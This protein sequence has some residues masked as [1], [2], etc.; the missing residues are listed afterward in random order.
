ML[1]VEFRFFFV[2]FSEFFMVGIWIF[3][4]IRILLVF[5]FCYVYFIIS[6][7]KIILDSRLE[8]ICFF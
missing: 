7:I 4:L 8:N 6:F 1:L 2:K 3:F 5:I